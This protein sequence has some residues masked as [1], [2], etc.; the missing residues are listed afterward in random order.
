[1]RLTTP[2][3]AV[4]G[5]SGD[6]GKTLLSIGLCRCFN[7]RGLAV[8][9]FKKGPDYIDAAWLAAAAR[10][11]CTNLDTFMMSRQRLEAGVASTMPSDLLLVEGNRGLYDGVDAAGSHSTAALAKLLELPVVLVVDVSKA[12][13]T[14]AAVVLGCTQLDP[15]VKLAGV[16]LN[17]VGTSRQ[18]RLIRQSVAETSGLEVI[19]ALPRLEQADLLPSRHLGLL[20]AAEH[21]DHEGAIARAAEAVAQYV[22]LDMLLEVA[23]QAPEIEL[24]PAQE[25]E[26]GTPVKIGYFLDDAFSF[27]YPENLEQLRGA[28]AELVT[29]RPRSDAALPRDV[30]ALYIGGGFPEV[31]ASALAH[32]TDLRRDLRRRVV[33]GLP[34]YAE[35]GGLMYLAR[36]LQVEG[37]A[38]P[39]AGVLDLVVEQRTRPQGHGYEVAV[40]D[41]D[42][43]FFPKDTQL[44]GHE[45]HYSHIVAGQDRQASVARCTKGEGVGDGRDAIVKHNVWASYLHLHALATPGWSKGLLTLAR[46]YAESRHGA[47]AWA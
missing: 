30:D 1:M 16:V 29:V 41:R 7:E 20:T 8:Q 15:Q 38:Y 37:V 19:G 39:M 26:R 33:D 6:G 18:E 45:F 27:Y 32:N 28:G 3:L 4:A 23:A 34:V 5:L 25:V 43:P 24:E 44:K 12:T 13:R 40:I 21:P 11:P 2:R 10:R 42:N 9:A 17:R 14:V 47:V 36:E 22:D 46:R 31:H 35:C